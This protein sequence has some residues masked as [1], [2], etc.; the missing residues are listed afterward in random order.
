MFGHKLE[1]YEVD[2]LRIAEADSVPLFS[3]FLFEMAMRFS[4]WWSRIARQIDKLIDIQ[5]SGT[6][7]AT[8][9]GHCT[10]Y[11]LAACFLEK[12]NMP[13]TLTPCKTADYPTPAIA[14]RL[15]AGE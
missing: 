5:G 12:V 7:H 10:W 13:H 1:V 11:D 4:V 6:Y 2:N 8:A 9:E 14:R 3:V 15:V